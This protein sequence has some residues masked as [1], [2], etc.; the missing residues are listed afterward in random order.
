[1]N[2]IY[3]NICETLDWSITSVGN[4]YVE[5]EKYSPAGEEIILIVTEEN[6]VEDI[7]AHAAHFNVDDHA[8]MW[9]GKRGNNGVPSSIREIL[10]DAQAIDDILR[11]LAC[12]LFKAELEVIGA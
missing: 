3:Q 9:I 8:E 7:K 10:E 1:M 6:F 11:E 4:S 5:L 12:A 2:E